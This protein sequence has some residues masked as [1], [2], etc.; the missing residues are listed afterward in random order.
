MKFHILFPRII[1]LAVASFL[2]MTIANG[3]LQALNSFDYE[4]QSSFSIRV[5]STD[6]AGLFTEKQFTV[7]VRDGTPIISDQNFSVDENSPSG[8]LVPGMVA[9]NDVG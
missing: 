2:M 5:R 8:T 3:Q 6:G 9:T 7:S 1:L 4:A